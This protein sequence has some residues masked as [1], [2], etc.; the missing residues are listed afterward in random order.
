MKLPCAASS[1]KRLKLIC[2]ELPL[3]GFPG[4][5]ESPAGD[6]AGCEVNR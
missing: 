6:R 2:S 3:Q 5:S 1:E 4:W